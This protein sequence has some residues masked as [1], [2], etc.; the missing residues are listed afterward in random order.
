MSTDRDFL[1]LA[2]V[3]RDAAALDAIGTG[4][5]FPDDEHLGYAMLAAWRAEL[6]AG[7][8][9]LGAGPCASI[10]ASRPDQPR[11]PARSG[12]TGRAARLLVAALAAVVLVLAGGGV[13]AAAD[14]GPDSLLWP[15][16]EVVYPDRVPSA[17]AAQEAHHR[18]ASARSALSAGRLD[19]ARADLAAAEALLGKVAGGPDGARLRADIARLRAA[20]AA[21][22]TTTAVPGLST[23]AT[24]PTPD[25]SPSAPPM[26]TPSATRPSAARPGKHTSNGP[27]HT[28]PPSPRPTP[29]STGSAAGTAAGVPPTAATTPTPEAAPTDSLGGAADDAIDPGYHGRPATPRSLR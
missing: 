7:I 29:G 13:L 8:P 2:G 15:I 24:V 22:G 18:L 3:E 16:T 10:L 12:M 26:S 4:L 25:A 20:L 14:A 27:V 19:A 5:P 28:G 9:A 21:Q 6:D 1:D 11:E 23:P 17:R